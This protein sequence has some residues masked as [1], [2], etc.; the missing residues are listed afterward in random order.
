M[1]L[2]DEINE[3]HA[4]WYWQK[5]ISIIHTCHGC[6]ALVWVYFTYIVPDYAIRTGISR[7]WPQ[8]QW[9]SADDHEQNVVWI[10][11]AV[12]LQYYCDVIMGAMASQ[13]TS[14][15]IAYSSVHS[16]T[17][18]RKHQSSASLAYVRGIHR[19]PVNSPHIWPVTRKIFPF[20]DVIMSK[21]KTWQHQQ[22]IFWGIYCT[23]N[24]VCLYVC[25]NMPR[26]RQIWYY[27]GNMFCK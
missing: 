25:G 16:G 5:H 8:W 26:G 17:D 14:F 20:D 18:Q 2:L 22:H 21:S 6:S 19:W 3:S 1:T 9:G 10:S 11:Q 23:D 15:T 24:Y 27:I 4:W 12:L 7:G 13:I